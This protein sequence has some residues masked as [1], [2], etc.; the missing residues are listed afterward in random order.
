MCLIY[1]VGVYLALMP[2]TLA[3][4]PSI[5]RVE[6]NSEGTFQLIRDGKPFFIRG[7]GG[8][9]H[10]EQLTVLGGNSLRTWGIEE[11]EK[12]IDGKRLID[13]AQ[14]LGIG[15]TVG[16]WLQ[17]ERHGFKYSDPAQ[18]E[19]Q[20]QAVRT[21]VEKYKDHPAVLIWG[22]GNEMEGPAADGSNVKIWEEVNHLAG[23]IK[24]IDPNHPVMTVIAGPQPL[25]IKNVL[26]FCPNIDILG[27][28]GYASAP[29]AG[30]AVVSAGWD[31][32]FI[33]AEFGPMGHWEVGKT[34][35]G[36]PVEATS[37]KKAGSYYAT[38][39]TVFTD[40]A[41][42]CIGS[43]AFLW[44][45]KQEA[46]STW[47]GMFL[48]DGTKLGT[49]DAMSYSWTGKWPAN[50]CPAIR[51]IESPLTEKSL[52]AGSTHPVTVTATDPEND[53]LTFDWLIMEESTDRR[54]GGDAEAVPPSTREGI[55]AT[56]PGKAEIT[57]PAKKGPYRLF[58]TVRD[59]KGSAATANLPFFSE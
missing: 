18:L 23:I 22:L 35:W 12:Q 48:P 15:L 55:R 51:N 29:G 38:Q 19:K 41:K 53:S 27:I 7:V 9:N 33:L 4:T 56:E 20:R 1:W 50:R 57:L 3:A 46:T 2:L 26:Q 32:P 52:P 25:K 5:V 13:R 14:E 45:H 30:S 6:K 43:Y 44:G 47:Y 49:V 17:H 21:A 59:G 28:N 16:I 54:E 36:A 37:S 40:S 8:S 10:L 11:M 58:I 24:S 39:K 31:R 34:S 42:I